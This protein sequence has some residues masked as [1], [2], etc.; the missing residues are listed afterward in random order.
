M[1][2]VSYPRFRVR[3]HFAWVRGILAIAGIAVALSVS[4]CASSKDDEQ[5]LIETEPADKLYNDGLALA[6]AGKYGA[7]AAKFEA[8]DRVH[9]Y[10]QWAKK[11]LIMTAYAY[12]EAGSFDEAIQAGRRFVSLHPSHEDAAYAYYIIGQSYLNQM[13]DISRDQENTQRALAAFDEIVKRFP[14]SEY[15]NDARRKIIVTYD[16]LAG[17]EME[18]GRYYLERR[19]YVGAINR[20][21]TVVTEAQTTR[22]VEEALARL[23]EAYMALGVVN[24]AQTAAAVLGHN[25]PDSPW[26]KDTYKLLQSGGLEPHEDRGSWISRALRKTKISG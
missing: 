12:Y 5:D 20:F 10:S 9:P 7:A 17:K 25:F 18:V 14:D 13:Q 21:K 6:N 16:Q 8:V 26:Y 19:N 11:S 23:A 22:H 2:E 3:S 15:A 24:E 4:A 1:T